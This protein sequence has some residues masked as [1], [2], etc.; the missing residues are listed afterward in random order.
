MPQGIG[1]MLVKKNMERTSGKHMRRKAQ[2]AACA[3]S[4]NI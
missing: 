2:A 1:A 4:E 3:A